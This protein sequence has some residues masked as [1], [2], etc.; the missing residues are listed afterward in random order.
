[1]SWTLY[2]MLAAAALAAVDVSVKL[3]TGRLPDGLGTL[4]YGAPVFGVGLLWFVAG[5]ARG[6]VEH[7]PTG[8]VVHS[9]GGGVAFVDRSA[10]IVGAFALPR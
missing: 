3:G 9:L 5:R 6:R 8:G 7:A 2:A 1:M 4:I 10:S